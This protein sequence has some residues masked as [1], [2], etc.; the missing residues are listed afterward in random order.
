MQVFITGG[1]VVARF[2]KLSFLHLWKGQLFLITLDTVKDLFFLVG[3]KRLIVCNMFKK[4]GAIWQCASLTT[5]FIF[6]RFST[7]QHKG[8]DIYVSLVLID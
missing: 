1:K 8:V 4:G 7:A 6:F 2:C 5:Q 3:R